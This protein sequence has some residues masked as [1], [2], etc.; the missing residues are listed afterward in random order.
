MQWLGQYKNKIEIAQK[1]YFENYFQGWII[2]S[3]PLKLFQ[4]IVMYSI[5]WGKRLRAILALEIFLTLTGKNIDDIGEEDDI[6][7]FCIALEVMHS[8]SLIHD[9]LP[10]MDN[11]EYR[12]GQLTVWKKYGEYNAVLVGDMLNT[13]AFEIIS[14]MR[15]AKISIQLIQLLSHSVWF[16]WMV[17]WQVEDMYFE[18]HKGELTEKFLTGLH[19]KKTGQLIKASAL[20]GSIIAWRQDLFSLL[21]DFSLKLWLAFQIKDDILDVEWSFEETGKSVWWEQK[22]FVFIHGLEASKKE[23]HTLL[24]SCREMIS[25]FQSEKLNSIV[26]YIETRKK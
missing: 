25:S 23:L 6:M 20:G 4:E 17:W 16:F 10:C 24:E 2:E 26:D 18:K 19:N 21:Q 11:D 14:H 9:D 8:F 3:E 7:K 12:R 22:G 15:D 1:K 5:E 13:L